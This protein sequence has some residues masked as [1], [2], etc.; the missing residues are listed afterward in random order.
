M[1]F[2]NRVRKHGWFILS[3]SLLFMRL[4]CWV[5]LI[6][7]VRPRVSMQRL[8]NL[9]KRN[10]PMLNLSYDTLNRAFQLLGA[11]KLFG[12]SNPCVPRSLVHYRFFRAIGEKPRYVIGIAGVDDGHAW[13]VL[14]GKPYMENPDHLSRYTP[15]MQ[16]DDPKQPLHRASIDSTPA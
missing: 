16:L 2:V 13:V 4:I 7:V 14:N 5:I 3:H 11:M 15:M 10:I 6:R 12:T 1:H 9:A 8:T